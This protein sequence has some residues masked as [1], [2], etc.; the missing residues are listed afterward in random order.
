M[1]MNQFV[2]KIG[3]ILIASNTDLVKCT[4]TCTNTAYGTYKPASRCS[5]QHIAEA[6][7]L[8]EGCAPRSTLM[9]LPWPNGTQVD[10]V[11]SFMIESYFSVF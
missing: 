2:L 3:L 1:K 10:Q 9:A 4:E 11:R 5:G 6:L 7:R 8:G